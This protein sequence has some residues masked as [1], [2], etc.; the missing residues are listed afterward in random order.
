MDSMIN[1]PLTTWYHTRIMVFIETLMNMVRLEPLELSPSTSLVVD[2]LIS[3]VVKLHVLFANLNIDRDLRLTSYFF[4][5]L[6][7]H[8]DVK[9]EKSATYHP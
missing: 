4:C 6:M 8:L 7:E 3:H 9:Q 2:P 1:L 5:K